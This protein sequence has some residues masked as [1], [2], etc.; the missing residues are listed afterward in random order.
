MSD[1]SRIFISHAGVDRSWAEWASWHLE[2]AGYDTE[3][4]CVDWKA[5]ENFVERMHEALERENPMLVLLS[6]AYLDPGRFTT[7][8]WTARFA[9]RRKDVDVKL[10]PVRIDNVDLRTGI[11]A[12]IIVPSLCDLPSEKAV[13]LLLESVG[14][15]LGPPAPATAPRYPDSPAPAASVD[16]G[17]RR[18]GSLP[19]VWN[20][21]RRNPAFTGR[22]GVLNQVHDGLSGAGRVAV[23]AL[24]GMGGVGK[25]QVALEYA[26]RFAGE[27]DLVWWVSAEQAGLI[28]EQFTALGVE[29]GLVEAGAD[30]TV[31]KS[32]V[33]GHLSGQQRWLL[34]F[35]NV[36]DSEDVLPWLP[37]GGGHVLIT[38][39]RGNWQQIAHAVELDVL[40]REEAVRFL[41]E[42]LPGVDNDEAGRLAESLGDLP[43]ALAQAAGYLAETGMAVAEYRQLLVEETRAVL[44]LGR[45][46]DYP[47]PLAA[48]I[49]LGVA[50]L[51]EVDPA[52]V[53]I[54]RLCALLAPEPI[55]VD[56]IVEV[57]QPTEPYPAM[58]APLPEVIG[59]P[60]V[61]QEAIGR[62]GAYGLARVGS[63]TV[64]VHRLTQAVVRT[65]MEPSAFA[66]LSVHLQAVLGRMYPGDPRDPASWPDWGRL[67]PH[68]LAV[69]PAHTDDPALRLCACDA[70][71]YLI[72][73]GDTAPARQLAVNLFEEWRHRLGAD[74]RDTLR[75]AS[76][77]IWALRDLGEYSRLQPLVADV[78]SRQIRTRGE[79]D[80]DT[81]RSASDLG[82]ILSL[83]GDH[84]HAEEVGRDVWQ[85]RRQVLG[86]EHP[87]TLRSASSVAATLRDLGR[88]QEALTLQ[89]QVWD[90]RRR[91]LGEEHPDTLMS[92]NGVASVLGELGDFQE[93]LTLWQQVR[94]R[95]R[96]VLGEEHPDTLMAASNVVSGLAKLGRY[97]EAMTLG[98][99]VWNQHRRVL[100]EEHPDTLAS[101][102]NVVS[103]L[104]ELGRYQ[105]ALTLGQQLW[106]QRGRALGEK[107]PDTL[108]SALSLAIA[109]LNQGRTLP[110][111]RMAELAW[112]GLRKQLGAQHPTT[113]KAAEVR[114]TAMQ[115]MGGQAGGNKKRRR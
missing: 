24:H 114:D 111:R 67:L 29:L 19:S 77:V 89:H 54:L 60:L 45:P 86:E 53:A 112:K 87:D 40:P 81:L 50:A 49:A 37:R 39:R 83:L 105:E 99:Q 97:Q 33:L 58:L 80:P 42:Q 98:Q 73:R 35:D 104:G 16:A 22:D 92:A 34:V 61:R 23:Q 95:Y 108:R 74:H 106:E 115:M 21:D 3:L 26:Y 113:Q 43:L 55:A 93:A 78:L 102:N 68:L 18:P 65:Q 52:A 94:E 84:Q 27:Y 96:Q 76:E 4:D 100:G 90:Q 44:D 79:S 85:R 51:S 75:A 30:S 72:G 13:Q 7:D 62:I 25:T 47:R 46:V 57:A 2:H 12:P 5:G 56:L 63:G 1:T 107:H 91:V 109:Y 11:W 31:A 66:E 36:V 32:K 70:V 64:T 17:P 38:S 71:V 28:G 82:I 41:A 10:I 59:R 101:A 48:S 8:E 110:G 14:G 15:V 20:V 6:S 9:Q 69:D 103:A 88:Y